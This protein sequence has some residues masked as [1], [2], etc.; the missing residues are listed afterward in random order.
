MTLGSRCKCGPTAEGI[1]P[2]PANPQTAEWNRHVH[3]SVPAYVYVDAEVRLP[4]PAKPQT[5]P[6]TAEGNCSVHA[7]GAAYVYV[8][9]EVIPVP[10]NIL[11]SPHQIVRGQCP[12]P[13]PMQPVD[14]RSLSSQGHCTQPFHHFGKTSPLLNHLQNLIQNGYKLFLFYHIDKGRVLNP[15]PR[16]KLQ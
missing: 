8:D 10:A 3:C 1:R 4:A 6:Q 9:A 11:V 12:A 14:D 7:Y 16:E 5:N 2:V 13:A 15:S